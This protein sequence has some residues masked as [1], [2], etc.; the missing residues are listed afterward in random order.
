MYIFQLEEG[1]M[2]SLVSS[3]AAHPRGVALSRLSGTLVS[4]CCS[5]PR[6]NRRSPRHICSV[7]TG[8]HSQTLTAQPPCLFCYAPGID[9][10]HRGLPGTQSGTAAGAGSRGGR[11]ALPWMWSSWRARMKTGSHITWESVP[12]LW[13][14]ANAK[15]TRSEE[16][17]SMYPCKI[18]GTLRKGNDQ[19]NPNLSRT[20]SSPGLVFVQTTVWLLCQGLGLL[21]LLSGIP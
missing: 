8:G 9:P 15:C 5:L 13:P 14:T 20:G 10:R 19:R 4:S 7:F 11:S 18:L 17:W 21:P 3:R 2:H 16:K 6:S 12:S 1:H